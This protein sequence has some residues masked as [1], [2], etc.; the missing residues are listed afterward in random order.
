MAHECAAS[1]Q[2]GAVCLPAWAASCTRAASSRTHTPPLPP[3]L[4][5]TIH[6]TPLTP[7]LEEAVELF[8]FAGRPRQ[9]LRI[10]NQRLSDAVEAAATST[11]RGGGAHSH[12]HRHRHRQP[13]AQAAMGSHSRRRMGAALGALVVW[14]VP[15]TTLLS[16]RSRTPS[17]SHHTPPPSHPPTAPTPAPCM[18]HSLAP[19]GQGRQPASMAQHGSLTCPPAPPCTL[20]PSHPPS[21]PPHPPCRRRG[22][23]HCE[24]GRCRGGSH[25]QHAGPGCVK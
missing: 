21:P 8:M 11:A 2:V 5:P 18:A 19:P 1:A 4:T 3:P 12:R 23:H 22:V 15:N 16:P 9:A 24:P 10:L 14:C 17:F 6:P 7:Q 25:G 20:P 13:Q